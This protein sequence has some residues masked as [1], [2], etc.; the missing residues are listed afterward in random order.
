MLEYLEGFKE[1]LIDHEVI[2][3]QDQITPFDFT[4]GCTIEETHKV[5]CHTNEWIRCK[6]PI[7]RIITSRL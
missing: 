6:E 7:D 2:F 5:Y 1:Y 4:K 3:S